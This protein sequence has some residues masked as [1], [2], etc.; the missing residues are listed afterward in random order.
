MLSSHRHIFSYLYK[1][2]C[3]LYMLVPMG[4]VRIC[5]HVYINI[6]HTGKVEVN[7]SSILMHFI[8]LDNVTL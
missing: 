1:D 7:S 4:V 2:M 3:V 8:V 6:E 5:G